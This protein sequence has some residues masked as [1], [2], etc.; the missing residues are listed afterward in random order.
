MSYDNLTRNQPDSTLRANAYVDM[1]SHAIGNFM[2]EPYEAK[3]LIDTY[4]IDMHFL[5][6]EVFSVYD[7]EDMQEWFEALQD[8]FGDDDI[9]HYQ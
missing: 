4:G 6:E 3:D 9:S 7:S 8:E 5:K 2:L 1:L